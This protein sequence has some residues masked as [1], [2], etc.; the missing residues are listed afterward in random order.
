MS[1]PLA[2]SNAP[3]APS[4]SMSPD[5]YK[6]L[7][8]Y[9]HQSTGIVLD[10]N[11]EY[12][13]QSRLSPIMTEMNI[14]S[15]EQLCHSLAKEPAGELSRVI[16]DVMTTNET[17]FF[18][19]FATFEALRLKVLP[20]LLQRIDRRK[21]RIWSAAASSGQEAYSLAMLLLEMNVSP[22]QV[23]II[24][25]DISEQILKKARVGQYVQFEVNRGLPTSLLMKYFD[26]TGLAWTI[27]DVIRKMVRFQQC[28]LRQVP[29]QVH[30]FDLLLCRNVLIYFDQPTK[31]QVL[32]TLYDNL[33]ESGVLVLGC[34]ETVINV[35]VPLRREIMLQTAFYIR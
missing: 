3:A 10:N 35:S 7:T 25:T 19:D 4:T 11:K 24:G 14:G 6:F 8:R 28:D 5:T 9:V 2:A 18:R 31:Q 17:L 29:E 26:R 12:L 13:L 15:M 22:S 16:A 33:E 20:D 1:S 30:K 23:E 21:L 27:K 34:A 32:K